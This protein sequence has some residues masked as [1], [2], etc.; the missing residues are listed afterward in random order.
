MSTPMFGLAIILAVLAGVFLFLALSLRITRTWSSPSRA[1]S[2]TAVNRALT[3]IARALLRGVVD[4]IT[5]VIVVAALLGTAVVL[6]ALRR[7]PRVRH[8]QVTTGDGG[9]FV[10]V[11]T[12][13]GRGSVVASGDV[14]IIVSDDGSAK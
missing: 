12:A 14:V 4:V 11:Q 6:F 10:Q 1:F 8:V 9:T 2:V 7:R 13:R 3:N 5:A